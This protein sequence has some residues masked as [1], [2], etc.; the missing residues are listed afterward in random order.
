MDAKIKNQVDAYVKAL[1]EK[2]NA[3]CID[4]ALVPANNLSVTDSK[5]GGLPYLSEDNQVPVNDEGE[6]LQFLAQYRLTDVP[7]QIINLPQEG[8]LQFWIANN[9]TYGFNFNNP[10]ENTNHRVIYYPTIDETITNEDIKQKYNPEINNSQPVQGTFKLTFKPNENA[11]SHA[12]YKFEQ[13]EEDIIHIFNED[14][15]EPESIYDMEDEV[16]EAVFEQLD[17]G[18]HRIGGHPHFTQDDPRMN[19]ALQEY[20]ILLLQIDSD[21]SFGASHNIQWGDSGICNFLI[22]SSDLAALDFSKVLYNWDCY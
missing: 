15:F 10:V 3:L 2:T 12:D 20:D 8:L 7:Q 22:K 5:I 17:Y 13:V 9:D 1:K 18:G 6:K 19:E 11:M 14:D 4:I 21:D 16:W